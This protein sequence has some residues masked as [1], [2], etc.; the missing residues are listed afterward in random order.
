MCFYARPEG[1]CDYFKCALASTNLLGSLARNPLKVTSSD[2]HL[3]L[4]MYFITNV[5][6]KCHVK[7]LPTS[8]LPSHLKNVYV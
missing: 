4:K 7:Q 6:N 1:K 3:F 2:E 8:D 5:I